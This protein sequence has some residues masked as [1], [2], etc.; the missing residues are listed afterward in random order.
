ME[1]RNLSVIT[2]YLYDENGSLVSE[3]EGSK[4]ASYQYDLLNREAH[5]TMPDGKEQEILEVEYSEES[6]LAH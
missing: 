3:K 4:T 1:R 5:V 2:E 6:W